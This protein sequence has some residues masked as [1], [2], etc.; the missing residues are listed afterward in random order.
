[1]AE[2]ESV[3]PALL[4]ERDERLQRWRRFIDTIT[5]YVWD[6]H[7]HR[8]LWREM[9]DALIAG[10]PEDSTFLD[11]YARLYTER[12]LIALRRLVDLD[13]RSISM[14]R[15]LTELAEHPETMSWQRHLELWNLSEESDD[16][17]DQWMV[18]QAHATFDRYADG[19]GENVDPNAVR[20]DLD[21]WKQ[22]CGKIKQVVDKRIAHLADIR[23]DKPVPTATYDDLDRAIDA[24]AGLVKKYGLLFTAGSIAQMEPVIQG[25][26]KAPFRKPLF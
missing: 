2:T 5:H 10:S 24:V 17:R 3:G 12:Q 22:A 8:A 19:D 9:R 11:H 23:S 6:L 13:P 15:L 21:G 14:A 1:V 26:W 16:P 4:A 25:D 20:A 7:H 18:Q